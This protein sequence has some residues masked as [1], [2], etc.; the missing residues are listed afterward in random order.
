MFLE[1]GYQA[2]AIDD[3]TR[4]AGVAR[5]TL[6]NRFKNKEAVF[7]AMIAD[8]WAQWGRELA[9]EPV[10]DEAP[11]EQHLQV[12]AYAIAAFQNDTQHVQFQKL[13]V[14]ESRHYDWIVPAAYQM[15][16]RPRMK[17]LAA[18]LARFHQEGRLYC[19][20]PEIAA[21]QFV[22]LVQEFIVWP[23]VMDADNSDDI[24]PTDIV[25]E[26][27]IATFMARYGPR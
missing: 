11:V 6:F 25:I 1:R 3:I 5:Q 2:V 20:Q 22:G 19:E 16:K 23:K 10:P 17:A 12:R 26:E 18:R 24:P 8:H 9:I 21:W 27:A 14:G 7:R 13:V 15:G 4:V